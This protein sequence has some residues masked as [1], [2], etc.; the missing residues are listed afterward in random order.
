MTNV[1]SNCEVQYNDH[2]HD[3]CSMTLN[4]ITNLFKCLMRADIVLLFKK[5]SMHYWYYVI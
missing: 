3:K 1:M 5:K 4:T 2:L